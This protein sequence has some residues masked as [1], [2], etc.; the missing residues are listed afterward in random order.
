MPYRKIIEMAKGEIHASSFP[1]QVERGLGGVCGILGR[2]RIIQFQD[3]VFF[4]LLL[5]IFQVLKVEYPQRDSQF[6]K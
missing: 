1:R 2:S 5:C 3:A 6:G 4:Q